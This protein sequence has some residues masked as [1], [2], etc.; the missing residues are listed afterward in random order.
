MASPPVFIVGPSRSGTSMLRE[1]L[2]QHP[3][4]WITRETHYF[5]DLRPRLRERARHT[6]SVEDRERCEAY[7][8]RL[9]IGPYGRSTGSGV[10]ATSLEELRNGASKLGG[11]ADAYFEAYCTGRAALQEKPRWGEK[12]PRHVYRIADLKAAFPDARIICL[13]RDPRAV[14]ASYR[15][16]K[17]NDPSRE[18]IQTAAADRRRIQRSYNVVLHALLWRSAMVAAVR[19]LE[20]Y[21][22]ESVRLQQYER[23]VSEPQKSLRALSGWLR[24]DYVDAMVDVPVI[25]SSYGLQG[26]GVTTAVIDRWQHKLPATEVAVIQSSCRRLMNRFGYTPVETDASAASVARMWLTGPAAAVRAAGA[27]HARIARLPDYVARRVGLHAT[28]SK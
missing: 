25:H 19:A 7:F 26:Q 3:E 22:R 5:D 24:L 8:Q 12:T 10:D 27:N 15:N 14:A 23:L 20:E 18:E 11:S 28:Y 2:N 16:W 21:G 4:L 1:M 6:L 13:V 9:G 17:R